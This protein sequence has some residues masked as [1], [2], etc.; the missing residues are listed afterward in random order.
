MVTQK[1]KS[2]NLSHVLYNMFYKYLVLSYVCSD[3]NSV[4]EN[5]WSKIRA[6]VL[7]HTRI[8]THTLPPWKDSIVTLNCNSSRNRMQHIQNNTGM[9]CKGD[10]SFSPL[11]HN[12]HT[13]ARAHKESPRTL[14]ISKLKATLKRP[15]LVSKKAKKTQFCILRLLQ[16]R[17]LNSLWII[18][19]MRL[20][21]SGELKLYWNGVFGSSR[22]TWALFP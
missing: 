10:I 22:L 17:C 20:F 19:K 8:D 5:P 9:L 12:T 7:L 14:A 3:Q 4:I 2:L 13:R 15:S 21:H 16:D 1:V 6:S 18:L 11:A